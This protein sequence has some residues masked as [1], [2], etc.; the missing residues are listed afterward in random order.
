M[1]IAVDAMGGDYAPAAVIEGAVQAL[2]DFSDIEE[3]FL[4]GDET[5]L[6][7]EIA[8]H[9]T[10][11]PR[12]IVV[13]ASQVVLMEDSAVEG[14]RRKK[15]SS[16]SRAVDLVKEGKAQAVVSAGHT[17]AAVAATTIKLRTLEGIERP[18]IATVLPTEHNFTVLIDAGAN[19]DAKPIHLLQYAIMGSVYSHDMLGYE[20]PRIGLMSIGQEDVKGNEL[21]KETFKL[22]E[23]SNL[24]FAGNIEG[25]DVFEGKVEVI[26]CDGFIGNVVLK[27][28]ESLAKALFHWLKTELKSNLLHM[29]GAALSNGAFKAIYHKTDPDESGGAP[30]L[31]INGVCIIGHGASSPKAIRNAIRVARES[32]CTHLTNHIVEQ[33]R[34]NHERIRSQNG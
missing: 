5:Q 31:G 24:N 32:I 29:T 22:L 15:D 23:R 7:R 1:K 20:K 10:P 16:I 14:I 3:L 28:S 27:T 19:I 9:G 4:V 21:T 13:H 33:V 12:A 2:R 26:V 30:L 34:I 18:G 8:R 6:R 11:D 25:H 17:G